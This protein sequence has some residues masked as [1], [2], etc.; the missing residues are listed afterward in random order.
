M[1]RVRIMAMAFC[2]ISLVVIAG[3]ALGAQEY[4][5]MSVTSKNI[6]WHPQVS[7]GGVSLSVTGPNDIYISRT[8][9]ADSL[10]S[11]GLSDN[12]G[13]HLPD[14][15]YSYELRFTPVTGTMTR[16][17]GQP[18][19][20]L[21]VTEPMVQSGSFR[22]VSGQFLVPSAGGEPAGSQPQADPGIVTPMDQ[23]VADDQIVQGSLCVGFDC[24]NNESFGFDTIRLKENN[25][26][27]KFEDTSVGSFP[28]ND[29]TIVANDS[30]SGGASY[31]AFEDT[32]G[33]K[34]PF[35][36]M[37][38]AP[39]N[40]L[41]VS[42]NG[43]VG[44]GTSTPILDL[45]VTTTDT[46]AHR[47]EQTSGGG[48]TAQTWDIGAN[49]ANFFVRDVTGGSRLPFRIRPGALTSSI[50]ISAAGNVGIGKA[51]ANYPLDVSTRGVSKPSV[52]FSL[53]GADSGGYLTSVLPNNF[54]L[55]SGAAWDGTLTT[56][57]WVAKSTSAVVAGSGDIGYRIF[58]ANNCTPGAVCAGLSS[59][60]FVIDY[61]GNASAT[62]FNQT[63]S[64]EY[65]DNIRQLSADAATDALMRLDPVTF[66]Y[67]MDPGQSHVGFIAEDVPDLVAMRDR[68]H[69]S[70]MDIVAVLTKVVQ[71]QS[72]KIEEQQNA[73]KDQQTTIHELK[74]ELDSL[75]SLVGGIGSR[76]MISAAC[77]E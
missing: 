16:R 6:V 51:S 52:H 76:N 39:T 15:Q 32:T 72:R 56:P 42:S 1:N 55:S 53:D 75:G 23:V 60:K 57:G 50:D 40:S 19:G 36:V 33:A 21:P 64:R 5:S 45:H 8:Y 3:D 27:I 4:A 69:L 11:I 30:A 71:E 18:T 70:P 67:K 48:F 17:G 77:P 35:K 62:S 44:F 74:R 66:T 29:W 54:F 43:N 47:F 9:V 10:P 65:K 68:K 26:R 12:E 38:E 14:G 13:S 58:L 34:T 22:I 63:S 41:Y 61:A 28:S 46:P 49:E 73:Y 2:L 59:A 7:N 37:A 25:T 20:T 31:L 24:V